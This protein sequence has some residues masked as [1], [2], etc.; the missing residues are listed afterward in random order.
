[1]ILFKVCSFGTAFAY[2]C[3]IEKHTCMALFKIN[4]SA[5][6]P[7]ADHNQQSHVPRVPLRASQTRLSQRVDQEVKP[8][9]YDLRGCQKG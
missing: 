4:N 2:Y 5:H 9:Y 3:V 7:T 6:D 8:H 1:L